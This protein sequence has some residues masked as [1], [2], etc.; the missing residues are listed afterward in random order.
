ML[1]SI[2]VVEEPLLYEKMIKYITM[3]LS[4]KFQI[5]IILFVF[6]DCHMNM[7]S[8]VEPIQIVIS[9]LLCSRLQYND[10]SA[11]IFDISGTH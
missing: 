4:L 3:K 6:L 5:L 2:I 10:L 8:V 1:N 7:N 11:L 9:I